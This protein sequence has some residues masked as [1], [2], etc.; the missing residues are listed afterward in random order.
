MLVKLISLL[1]EAKKTADDS[2][3]IQDQISKLLEEYSDPQ[4]LWSETGEDGKPVNAAQLKVLHAQLAQAMFELGYFGCVMEISIRLAQVSIRK[5]FQSALAGGAHSEAMVFFLDSVDLDAK[6]LEKNQL[7]NVAKLLKLANFQFNKTVDKTI[8]SIIFSE[9]FN[10][11]QVDES[12]KYSEEFRQRLSDSVMLGLSLE[13][14]DDLKTSKTT[15]VLAKLAESYVA[16]YPYYCLFDALPFRALVEAGAKLGTEGAV[17][18]LNYIICSPEQNFPGLGVPDIGNQRR[19]DL[20]I[21]HAMTVI[22]LLLDY[23]I[24]NTDHLRAVLTG[25]N[26]Y[27]PK[28]KRAPRRI[29]N[30]IVLTYIAVL[31]EI[32]IEKAIQTLQKCINN[33]GKTY[34]FIWSRLANLS[35]KVEKYEDAFNYFTNASSPDKCLSLDPSSKP[36]IKCENSTGVLV[37]KGT[38]ADYILSTT[39][40]DVSNELVKLFCDWANKAEKTQSFLDLSKQVRKIPDEKLTAKSHSDLAKYYYNT[41]ETDLKYH[42]KVAFILQHL[43]CV[44]YG[45]EKIDADYL[46]TKL[47]NNEYELKYALAKIHDDPQLKPAERSIEIEKLLKA[48]ESLRNTGLEFLNKLKNPSHAVNETLPPPRVVP[49]PIL[50]M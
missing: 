47:K 18:F 50:G 1:R 29:T 26:H 38:N 5:F 24:I 32:G 20:T 8:F 45:K 39:H 17:G 4:L 44:S 10:A 7:L 41:E 15:S 16:I 23:G 14:E 37:K 33:D 34:G 46:I 36:I 25:E 22:N 11:G 31:D 3:Q 19:R 6:K 2:D 42:E 49:L 13:N 48:D 9:K 43:S 21:V 40:L 12:L 30:E 27:D 28:F 35:Q